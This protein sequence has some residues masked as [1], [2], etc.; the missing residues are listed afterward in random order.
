MEQL[1]PH[2]AHA[3]LDALGDLRGGIHRV[4]PVILQ[5]PADIL[6][7]LG[8]ECEG[9]RPSLDLARPFAFQRRFHL[10]GAVGNSQRWHLVAGECSIWNVTDA[11]WLPALTAAGSVPP[12]ASRSHEILHLASGESRPATSPAEG[13]QSWIQGEIAWNRMSSHPIRGT[14]SRDGKVPPLLST[15]WDGRLSYS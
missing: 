5:I 4:D 7:L 11:G 2:L 12:F 13:V 8:R 6:R 3:L 1:A 15:P 9:K 14:P 10:P